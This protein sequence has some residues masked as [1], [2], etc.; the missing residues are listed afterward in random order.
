MT[1]NE[2][3]LTYKFHRNFDL[4]LL[5]SVYNRT[6]HSAGTWEPVP[7]GN[8]ILSLLHLFS[9]AQ[10]VCVPLCVSLCSF[11]FYCHCRLPQRSELSCIVTNRHFCHWAT[12]DVPSLFRHLSEL[13]WIDLSEIVTCFNRL[14]LTTITISHYMNKDKIIYIFLIKYQYTN[15][16]L[17]KDSSCAYQT[18]RHVSLKSQ[19]FFQ[20]LGFATC[21]TQL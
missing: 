13:K 16:Y 6:N 3:S 4:Q 15:K 7:E 9:F 2:R 18:T 20:F 1:I 19:K 8:R 10:L 12:L 17:D 11:C 5:C 14:I 21:V